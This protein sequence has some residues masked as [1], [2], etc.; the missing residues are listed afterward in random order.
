MIRP[1]QRITVDAATAV[2]VASRTCLCVEMAD[3]SRSEGHHQHRHKAHLSRY[4]ICRSS[5]CS[6]RS[7]KPVSRSQLRVL[8]CVLATMTMA[9]STRT[10]RTK[11]DLLSG[12]R[13]TGGRHGASLGVLLG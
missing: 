13:L 9:R 7:G 11:L 3:V 1:S 2:M 10:P 12:L 5:G 8:F 4:A 6:A